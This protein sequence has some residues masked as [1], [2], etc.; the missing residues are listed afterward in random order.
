M[1]TSPLASP[2]PSSWV[3]LGI[4][5]IAGGVALLGSYG[6]GVAYAKERGARFS[7]A[8]FARS[9][10]FIALWALLAGGLAGSGVL[11]RMDLRPPPF[12][13]VFLSLVSLG[14]TL[15]LGR[16][17][18]RLGRLPL[19]ALVGVH[20]FRVPLELV[21]HR[22][23]SEGVMPVQMS[24]SGLNFDIVTGLTAI[25]VAM[26]AARGRAPRALLVG[27]N[28]LGTALLVTIMTIAMV[29]TPLF[30]AFGSEPH[31]VNTWVAHF[32]FVYLPTVLVVAAITGHIVLWRKLLVGDAP[33]H[34]SGAL[35]APRTDP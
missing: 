26:L 12:V 13:L 34:A 5:V 8:A 1:D 29:S 35:G 2:S 17:G 20:A 19:V 27:W 9:V 11:L 24:Y 21:M 25:P 30:Q 22:A 7:P 16:V 14:L 15:G 33:G 32:P 10:T 28:A 3:F 6:Y 18:R 4:P 31:Q 23:A